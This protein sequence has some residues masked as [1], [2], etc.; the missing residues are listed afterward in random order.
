[1]L[2]EW[3]YV[4]RSREYALPWVLGPAVSMVLALFGLPVGKPTAFAITWEST[5][6]YAVAFIAVAVLNALVFWTHVRTQFLTWKTARRPFFGT[7][8]LLT[9]VYLLIFGLV[10][11][12]TGQAA[13]S[14]RHGNLTYTAWCMLA[15]TCS[16][17]PAL[18]VSALWKSEEPGVTNIRLQR[19]VALQILR[20]L[21]DEK[22]NA[23]DYRALVEVLD[24]LP[25]TAL[26][27]QS[28]LIG[29]TDR[30]LCAL[31]SNAA[32]EMYSAL[33]DKAVEDYYSSAIHS[34]LE[35]TMS[36]GQANLERDQ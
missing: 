3:F 15:G 25:K 1:M 33:R 29:Q 26:T 16:I 31:W 30:N 9:A 36:T 28:Q 10:L 22:V 18:L 32:Q 6:A 35:L 34:T 13:V 21:H 24:T 8:S 12:Q 2:R 23:V 7:Y 19:A 14:I 11:V 4:P 27:A 17:L 20:C 5:L